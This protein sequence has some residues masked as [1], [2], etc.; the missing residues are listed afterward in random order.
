MD[1]INAGL[2]LKFRRAMPSEFR[3]DFSVRKSSRLRRYKDLVDAIGRLDNDA[4]RNGDSLVHSRSND[5]T[6][7]RRWSLAGLDKVA[8]NTN[9]K[10]AASPSVSISCNEGDHEVLVLAKPVLGN[11]L[12]SVSYSK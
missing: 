8:A 2:I 6:E 3:C 11:N 7:L 5:F 4:R 1:G 9:W 12:G 10:R